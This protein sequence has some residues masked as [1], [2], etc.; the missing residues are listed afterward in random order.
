M[1]R[2]GTAP[3]GA[4]AVSDAQ[5][6]DFGNI[7]ARARESDPTAWRQLYEAHFDF[8][9]GVTR[10]LG[11]PAEEVEDVVQEVFLV[12]FRKLSSFHEGRFTTW[13]YRICANIVSDRHRRRRR[14]RALDVFRGFVSATPRPDPEQHAQASSAQRAVQRVLEHMSP[15]KREVFALF[16]IDGLSSD[17]IAEHVGC[18]AATVRTRLFHARQEFV[19]I[20]QR[21]GVLDREVMP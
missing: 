14:R 5:S 6:I 2:P 7:L 1:K 9:F 10:K 13:I 19:R 17:E 16:E 18:P 3:E 12:V 21:Q 20:A 4:Q 8:V 15:K 11:T